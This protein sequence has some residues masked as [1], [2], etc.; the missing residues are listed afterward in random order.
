M[1]KNRIIG[2]PDYIP[3]E[4]VKGTSVMHKTI[5]WWSLGVIIYEIICGIPPFND[6]TIENIFENIK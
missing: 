4:V 3:I 1:K 6:E 2:T 5:D